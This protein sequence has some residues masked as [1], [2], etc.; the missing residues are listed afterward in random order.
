MV[1]ESHGKFYYKI[2]LYIWFSNIINFDPYEYLSWA[3]FIVYESE[4]YVLPYT[5]LFLLF[6]Q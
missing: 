1:G 3:S 5:N 2:D 6:D 4:V